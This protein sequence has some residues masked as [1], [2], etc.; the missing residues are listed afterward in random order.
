MPIK[1][2]TI[3]R[4][5]RTRFKLKKKGNLRLSVFRSNK[6]LYAQLIDDGLSKTLVSSASIQK[7]FK[8]VKCS[9]KEM[10][11]KIGEDIGSKILK[12]N[13]EKK[14]CL[15]RGGY[16]FHGRVKEFALG[17]KSKGIKI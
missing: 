7:Q 6:F 2:T 10:A 13:I 14:I 16:L 5:K 8:D 4:S 12:K 9:P 17:V 15:G 3:R 11:F 1:D